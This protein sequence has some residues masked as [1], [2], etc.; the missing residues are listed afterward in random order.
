MKGTAT[1]TLVD[2]ARAAAETADP[3]KAGK[4]MAC[5]TITPR[6]TEPGEETRSSTT[7]LEIMGAGLAKQ[8][9]AG[10]GPRGGRHET[11]RALIEY[12]VPAT[13]TSP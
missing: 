3:G 6:V 1:R 10:Q 5:R 2:L 8:L 11:R 13:I 4:T 9:G 12:L 7:L